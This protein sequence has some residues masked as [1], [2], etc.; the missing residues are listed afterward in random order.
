MLR[1]D[2]DEERIVALLHD[3][4]EDTD[5]TLGDLE[6]AGFSEQI[7]DAIDYLSRRKDCEHYRDYISRLKSS[8]NSLVVNYPLS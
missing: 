7:V 4:V 1:V 3:V 6:D 2:T 5:V 8:T